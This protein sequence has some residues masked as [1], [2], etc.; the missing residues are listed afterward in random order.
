VGAQLLDFST[1]EVRRRGAR[2]LRLC[3]SD[4]PDEA[5]AQRLYESRGLWVYET[6]NRIL[7][8]ELRRELRLV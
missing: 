2:L 8:R 7:F 3:T 1:A 6:R 5:V 4:D